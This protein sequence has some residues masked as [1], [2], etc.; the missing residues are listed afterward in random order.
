MIAI[1]RPN[2]RKPYSLQ[3]RGRAQS[4]GA[5][6][7][8]SFPAGVTLQAIDGGESYYGDHGY[9]FAVN[10]GWDDSGFF[11]MGPFD[12]PY[13][14]ATLFGGSGSLGNPSFV[15]ADIHWNTVWIFDGGNYNSALAIANGIA[16]LD[17][18]DGAAI[19]AAQA[20]NI[21]GLFTV[22]EPQRFVGS[23]QWNA[24]VAN[25]I[26]GTANSIQDGRFWHVN[27]TWAFPDGQQWSGDPVPHTC[28]GDLAALIATP[29]ATTRHIDIQSA[30]IY[31]WSGEQWGFGYG[32][33]G[34]F[35]QLYG[36]TLTDDAAG[37]AKGKRGT[38]YGDMVD[39]QRAFQLVG[40]GPVRGNAPIVQIIETG[41]A[42]SGASQGIMIRPDFFNWAAWASII[43]GARGFDF[44]DHTTVSGTYLSNW[45]ML[46]TLYQTPYSGETI[47]IYDQVKATCG[48]VL[49]LA[50]VINSM[51]A[52]GYATV[53]PAGYVFPTPLIVI[54]NGIDVCTHYFTGAPYS[55]GGISFGKGFYIFATPRN[56]YTDTNIS[57]TF[58]IKNTGA[59]QAMVIGE[60]RN[61]SIS[62]GTT[63]TDT[64]AKASTVHI[65]YIAFP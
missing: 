39:L 52:V 9:T 30:D 34:A 7:A 3:F 13:V 60:S 27:N 58:T 10:M 61:V 48:R 53:S 8:A 16:S 49:D 14:N 38:N 55:S 4:G 1:S 19:T 57:A 51:F 6:S 29:N 23:A 31:F 40:G 62:S 12:G 46:T 18:N 35:S 50:R 25:P 5:P 44:F 36:V 2:W 22:D 47:S 17:S 24:A 43:H 21:V 63:F 32:A 64:F 41:N 20:S 15:Y 28:A 11:P 54:Q 26:G 42:F 45:N 59:A 65:Y 37:Y 56:A 33:G